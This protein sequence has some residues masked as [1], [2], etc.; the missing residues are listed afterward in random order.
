MF[1]CERLKGREVFRV[2]FADRTKAIIWYNEQREHFEKLRDNYKLKEDVYLT[3]YETDAMQSVVILNGV[4]HAMYKVDSPSIETTIKL[5]MYEL[6]SLKLA[7]N[8]RWKDVKYHI[9]NIQVHHREIMLAD[10]DKLMD[11]IDKGLSNYED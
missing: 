8:E 10:I 4:I 5:N 2:G 1:V 3:V 9:K 6:A 7:L 11:K